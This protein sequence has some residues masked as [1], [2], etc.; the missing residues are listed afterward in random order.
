[1]YRQIRKLYNCLYFATWR[2]LQVSKK[3]LKNIVIIRFKNECRNT[4]TKQF[5]GKL[6]NFVVTYTMED[7]CAINL[8]NPTMLFC[9]I[10]LFSAVHQIVLFG[11]ERTKITTRTLYKFPLVAKVNYEFRVNN[12]NFSLISW[13]CSKSTINTLEDRDWVTTECYFSA[14]IINLEHMQLIV[15]FRPLV[16]FYTPWNGVKPIEMVYIDQLH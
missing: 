16:S 13:I 4:R 2:D 5:Y 15:P 11:N 10:Y 8:K 6:K 7:T 12:K 3:K 14:F 1:M 9:G